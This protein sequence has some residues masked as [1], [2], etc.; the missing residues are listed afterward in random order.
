MQDK[1]DIT[2]ECNKS[3]RPI[4]SVTDKGAK[5]LNYETVV[6]DN[7]SCCDKVDVYCRTLKPAE[8][9]KENSALRAYV[10]CLVTIKY[11]F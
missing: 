6:T 2:H 5:K 10:Q 8:K 9:K 3:T 1:N 7:Y 11:E 4:W